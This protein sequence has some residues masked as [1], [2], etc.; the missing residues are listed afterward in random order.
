[1]RQRQTVRREEPLCRH[2]L[3]K[4]KISATT[5][6]DHIKPLSK[7]GLNSRSNLQGLCFDCHRTKSARDAGHRVKRGIGLDGWPI[8]TD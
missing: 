7:G 8:A 2:C 6:V 4:G 1:M 3:A 5:E